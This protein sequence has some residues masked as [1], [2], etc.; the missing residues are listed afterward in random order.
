VIC[1]DPCGTQYLRR[2]CACRLGVQVMKWER[3]HMV[4]SLVRIAALA[5]TMAGCLT[6]AVAQRQDSGQSSSLSMQTR[7]A[8]WKLQADEIAGSLDLSE[9]ARV[10]LRGIYLANRKDLQEQLDAMDDGE[11]SGQALL[12]DYRKLVEQERDKFKTALRDFLNE[13][14][15]AKAVATLGTFSRHWD[16]LLLAW[17]ELGLDPE[18]SK[19]GHAMIAAYIVDAE[20]VRAKVPE[21]S[22]V[23]SVRIAA[24][25]LKIALN[26][27][28]A[29]L[30]SEEQQIQ[31][32]SATRFGSGSLRRGGT[33][34]R[35]R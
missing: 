13:D 23:D 14:Q 8:I 1:S 9:E 16:R 30:L 2:L 29:T 24:E 28:L 31:W 22:D 19:Q 4:S 26:L 5:A 6:T 12:D 25:E 20:K 27:S 18:K 11:R 32:E 21:N 34:R 33:G 17:E 10:K 15:I 35:Y 3:A 7:E